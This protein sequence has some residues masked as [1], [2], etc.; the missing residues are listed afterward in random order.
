MSDVKIFQ[1]ILYNDV[2]VSACKKYIHRKKLIKQ[3]HSTKLH[4]PTTN[5]ANT[6]GNRILNA[7]KSCKHPKE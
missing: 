3:V 5:N 7:H 2:D 1:E 4:S 6:N